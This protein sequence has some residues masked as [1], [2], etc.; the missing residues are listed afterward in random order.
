MAS[1][2]LP[3]LVA[4]LKS[5]KHI[6]W[7]CTFYLGLYVSLYRR[8]PHYSIE[9]HK[10]QHW[11]IWPRKMSGSITSKSSSH[12]LPKITVLVRNMT[13]DDQL[14][15]L[16]EQCAHQNTFVMW[17]QQLKIA[18]SWNRLLYLKLWSPYPLKQG[19]LKLTPKSLTD[20]CFRSDQV[21]PRFWSVPH[22]K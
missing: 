16:P 6:R 19:Y 4:S 12:P 21:L 20:D 3:S 14:T 1:I 10:W 5:T 2:I 15:R 17:R 11:H 8:I 9:P 22:D 13:T 7:N 18:W